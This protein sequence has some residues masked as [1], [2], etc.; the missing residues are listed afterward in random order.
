V[1]HFMS[2]PKALVIGGSLGGLMTG[3]ELQHA[4]CDVEIFERSPRTLADRGA[5]IVMQA[6]TLQMLTQRCGLAEDESGVWLHQRQ[7]LGHDGRP[8]SQQ[9]L[10][11]LMTS[12][13]LLQRAF[14][15]AFPAER[16]HA[17]CQ[18]LDFT[19][20]AD[21]VSARFANGDQLRGDLL[22]GADGSRSTIRQNLF[23]KVQ[24]RYAG[25]VAWRGV[26]HERDAGAPLLATFGDRFTFQQMRHSHILCYLIP[27]EHGETEPGARRLN[28]VWYWN[29]VA[30]DLPFLMTGRDKRQHEFSIPPGQLCSE[31]IATQQDIASRV[32]CPQFFELWQTTPEPFLQPILDLSVPRMVHGRV[33]LLGDAA[34]IPRPHTAASTSKAAANAIALGKAVAAQLGDLDGALAEWEPAQLDLGRRLEAH[35]QLLGNRSQF[36]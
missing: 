10:P 32:L 30:E 21:G 34:F 13:G 29:V 9:P 31:A 20:E 11:Q 25:Y 14:R 24:P 16:Y 27:G 22:I 7:Y 15:N 35:G 8:E 3:I 19:V 2:R 17:G 1:R 4:G 23:P 33:A 18:L 26:V 12:W 6:E 28:W 5:G 36:S